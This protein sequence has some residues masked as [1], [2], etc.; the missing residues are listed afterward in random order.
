MERSYHQTSTEALSPLL[1]PFL[2]Q[3]QVLLSQSP[4]CSFGSFWTVTVR[5]QNTQLVTTDI[6]AE[7]KPQKS[8]LLLSGL[9]LLGWLLLHTHKSPLLMDL[10][11]LLLDPAKF[12]Q[13]LQSNLKW[14]NYIMREGQKERTNRKMSSVMKQKRSSLLLF[15]P[16]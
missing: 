6:A 7:F 16:T 3:Q 14:T 5:S 10:S 8:V 15:W 4:G 13:H 9:P 2:R 12:H 11:C 1:A